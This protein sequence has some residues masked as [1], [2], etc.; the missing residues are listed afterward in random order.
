M[1]QAV[2]INFLKNKTYPILKR[3][4]LEVGN[5]LGHDLLI[6]KGK[7]VA[8]Q[9]AKTVN[10]LGPCIGVTIYSPVKKFIAHSAPELDTNFE[11]I[12]N[13]I[14]KKIDELRVS[15]KCKDED[16]SAVIYG[17]IA[18]DKDNALSEASCSLVDA[19][20]EGC[21]LE[22][23]E[24]TIITGQF[25]DGLDARINSYIGKDQIT[26]WGKLIDKIRATQNSTQ[27]EIQKI[28]EEFFEY[29]NIPSNT[30]LK[31]IE[32]LPYKTEH[33]LNKQA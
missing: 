11:G 29:V 33:L 13:S 2:T 32:E 6:S 30:K 3:S 26:I 22:C 17:G 16:I 23:V 7:T 14:S 15:S 31:V 27:S 25:S 12:T 8:N 18:Y 9:T 1:P 24:P 5:S 21:K 4:S 10:G 19:I 28:L 20:E